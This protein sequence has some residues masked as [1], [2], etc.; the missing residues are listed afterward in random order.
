MASTLSHVPAPSEHAPVHGQGATPFA[1]QPVVRTQQAYSELPWQ[2]H[3]WRAQYEQWVE[4][5][6]ALQA[7]VDAP[8]ATIRDLTQRLYGTSGPGPPD[9]GGPPSTR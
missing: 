1:L 2:A 7:D 5:A 6:T 8:Q 4:R 9:R 3:S